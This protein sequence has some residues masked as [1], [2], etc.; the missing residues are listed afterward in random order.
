MTRYLDPKIDV[1]F[2]MKFRTEL[3]IDPY[4]FQLHH[5]HFIMLI[6]SCFSE[7]IGQFL[8]RGGF[9]VLSNPFGTLFN[10]LS[11]ANGLR[12]SI[13]PECFSENYIYQHEN[14]WVSFAH[15]GKFSKLTREELITHVKTELDQ[16]HQFLQK[17]DF[18]FLTFGTAFYYVFK[19]RE[20]LVANCHK[21]PAK[22]FEKKRATID[23]IIAEYRELFQ[24][25]KTFNPKLKIVFT[26]SPIRHLGDGFHE[27]QISKS[28]LH[29]AVE[30]L[31]ACDECYYFPS[32]ELLLDDLR[33]YRFFAHDLC[34]PSSS[35]I[36]YICEKFMQAFFSIETIE[37]RNQAEKEAKAKEHISNYFG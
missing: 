2:K 16:S 37:R 26:V 31:L 13:S 35:A 6:G 22:E 25:L 8:L 34:H 24:K 30:E 29:V 15:H 32:Y 7:H 19:S 36:E 23:N 4:P 18:L 11:I 17:A 28:I 3:T 9:P 20:L 12:M 1:L 10:P 27:N 33:D 21:I 5:N 14:R